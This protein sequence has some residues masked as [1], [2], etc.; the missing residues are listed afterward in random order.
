MMNRH[1]MWSCFHLFTIVAAHNPS[2]ADLSATPS[3]II[4]VPNKASVS[5]VL[6]GKMLPGQKLCLRAGEPIEE[7]LSLIHI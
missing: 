2:F 5:Q 4:D 7:Y 1:I 3:R 6:Y